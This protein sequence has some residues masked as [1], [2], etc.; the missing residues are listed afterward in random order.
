[1]Y[2]V[3]LLSWRDCGR[4]REPNLS[5]NPRSVIK[6]PCDLRQVSK[7]LSLVLLLSTVE[8]KNSNHRKIIMTLHEIKCIKSSS[9]FSYLLFGG[10]LNGRPNYVWQ[11]ESCERIDPTEKTCFCS[12]LH[13]PSLEVAIRL[14]I[15]FISGPQ[16]LAS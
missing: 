14:R 8:I 3:W 1:M 7:T 9:L 2:I 10:R 13:L 5:L 15:S 16:K 11:R 12:D 6:W 4:L